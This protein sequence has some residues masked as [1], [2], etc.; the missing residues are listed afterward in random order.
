MRVVIKMNIFNCK[1]VLNITHGCGNIVLDR[2][3]DS[4]VPDM[5]NKELAPFGSVTHTTEEW[6]A[7]FFTHDLYLNYTMRINSYRLIKQ[8]SNMVTA[9]ILK[10][11]SLQNSILKRRLRETIEK[12]FLEKI[13]GNNLAVVLKSC[14][15]S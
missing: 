2:I 9:K 15:I 8:K 1:I 7:G 10:C 12:G 11:T 14:T 6:D 5:I 3:R 13:K 4:N